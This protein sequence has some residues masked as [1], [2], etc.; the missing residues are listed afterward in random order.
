MNVVIEHEFQV[1]SLNLVSF[2]YELNMIVTYITV[3][4]HI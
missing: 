3:A 4:L 2:H 1:F